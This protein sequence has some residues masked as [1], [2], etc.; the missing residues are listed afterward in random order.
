MTEFRTSPVNWSKLLFSNSWSVTS[1]EAH[2]HPVGQLLH[3]ALLGP[4]VLEPNLRRQEVWNDIII[5]TSHHQYHHILGEG[6][7]DYGL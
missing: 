7:R 1:E 4:L 2:A 5:T 3:P 6:K